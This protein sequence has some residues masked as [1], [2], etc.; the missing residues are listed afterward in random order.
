MVSAG[1]SPRQLMFSKLCWNS[2]DSRM[3]WIVTVY[4]ARLS[5]TP[6]EPPQ[7]PNQSVK[8][9]QQFTAL[10]LCVCVP[11]CVWYVSVA[12]AHVCMHLCVPVWTHAEA[13]GRRYPMTCYLIAFRQSFLLN[14]DG[15][16]LSVSRSCWYFSVYP[17]TTQGYRC[18][19]SH[20]WI[21][22]LMLVCE[23]KHSHLHSKF[24][25]SFSHLA[26]PHFS[27]YSKT[28]PDI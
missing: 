15:I 20:P 14:V 12:Y 9:L 23:L 7:H 26:S 17:W 19:S 8:N 16:R 22:I 6:T 13:T 18:M 11:V 2:Q 1:F 4:I 28:P 10:L 5:F 3:Y 27:L 21:F 25:C 24:T